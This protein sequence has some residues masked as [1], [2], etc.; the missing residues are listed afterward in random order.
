MNKYKKPLKVC[1]SAVCNDLL[2]GIC[3]DVF[4]IETDTA[5]YYSK[6]FEGQPPLLHVSWVLE[7]PSR[8]KGIDFEVLVHQS[9][10]FNQ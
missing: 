3:Y 8:Q 10:H 7:L 9:I 4:H 5:S 2:K 1:R 6:C